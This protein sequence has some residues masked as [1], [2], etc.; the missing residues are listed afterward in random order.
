[1]SPLRRGN[2]PRS[3]PAKSYSATASCGLAV[4]AELVL[5]GESLPARTT[6]T[7]A[8]A[9]DIDVVDGWYSTKRH[10][11]GVGQDRG[12]RSAIDAHVPYEC[13]WEARAHTLRALLVPVDEGARCTV[14]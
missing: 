9:N 8:G 1:M 5:A 4:L 11:G 14:R 13:A 2:S 12:N 10:G 3:V 6:A 7:L